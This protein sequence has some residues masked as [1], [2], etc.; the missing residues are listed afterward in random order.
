LPG[1]K[2]RTLDSLGVMKRRERGLPRHLE[3]RFREGESY[4]EHIPG[5][6]KKT[7]IVARH[8]WERAGP[9]TPYFTKLGKE[10]PMSPSQARGNGKRKKF[11]HVKAGEGGENANNLYDN[12]KRGEWGDGIKKDMPWGPGEIEG[13]FTRSMNE[14]WMRQ[15]VR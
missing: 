12:N 10:G 14:L 9:K 13:G 15:G 4:S 8:N 5:K 7:R 3:K 11:S 6:K 2:L 1:G